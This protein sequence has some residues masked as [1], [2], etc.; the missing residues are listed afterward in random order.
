MPKPFANISRWIWNPSKFEDK[1]EFT[2]W[3]NEIVKTY[4][5]A[6]EPMGEK[7]VHGKV[8][9]LEP[10]D[11]ADDRSTLFVLK[12]V[13]INKNFSDEK[14]EF[15]KAQLTTEASIG[16]I[17]DAPVPLVW[18]YR[19]ENNFVEIVMENVYETRTMKRE[20]VIEPLQ[21]YMNKR[22]VFKWQTLVPLFHN[23]MLA[24]YKKTLYFHGDLHFNNVY[25]IRT[26]DGSLK[27]IKVIDLGSVVPF[28]P[29]QYPSL[30]RAESLAEVSVLI[31][32]VFTQLEERKDFELRETQPKF[33][34]IVWLQG[35]TSV[36]HNFR[37]VVP[38]QR[39]FWNKVL[40]VRG[41]RRHFL[42]QLLDAFHAKRKPV[43]SRKST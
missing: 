14:K 2:I 17:P 37:R 10:T 4:T 29:K 34:E 15:L 40:N 5:L 9:T 18:A 41:V 12:R 11:K 24:F 38:I 13:T 32:Q 26:H 42:K 27:R 19:V 3:M 1:M 28:V 33:G 16:M 6:S 30:K 20:F 8:Y 31:T 7:S 23:T 21:L 39:I 22:R 25:V 36:I 35:D 43:T